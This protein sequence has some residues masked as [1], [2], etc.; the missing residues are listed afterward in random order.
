MAADD[1]VSAELAAIREDIAQ[2][3]QGIRRPNLDR[4][5]LDRHAPRLLAAVEAVL[6][7]HPPVPVYEVAWH[8]HAP[9]PVGGFALHCGHPG[10]ALE[11]DRHA[12][13][14]EGDWIC[15]DQLIHTACGGCRDDT[16]EPADFANCATR[17]AI[18][19]ELTQKDGTQ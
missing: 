14:G 19:R 18:K 6:A 4:R 9:S 3:P 12:E 10:T 16:G 8:G 17:A 1:P 13:S 7:V 11:D 2:L 5:I 15:L